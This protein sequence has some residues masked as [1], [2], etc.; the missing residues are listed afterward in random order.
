MMLPVAPVLTG[1]PVLV[2][3]PGPHQAAGTSVQEDGES[4]TGRHPKVR[5]AQRARA[6]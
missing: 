4:S 6:R 2:V 1:I 3:G 5:A